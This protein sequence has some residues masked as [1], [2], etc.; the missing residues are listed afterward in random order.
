MRCTAA[1][2]HACCR[3]QGAGLPPGQQRGLGPDRLVLDLP[4]SHAAR[5][6]KLPAP[7]GVVAAVR[8]GQPVPG[9]LRIVFTITSTCV[10]EI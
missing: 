7:T 9:T 1:S 2:P 10:R 6:L 5:S 8:T 4:D 3:G